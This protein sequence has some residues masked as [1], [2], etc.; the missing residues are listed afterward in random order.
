MESKEQRYEIGVLG[1]VPVGAVLHEPGA[2]FH[3]EVARFD[4]LAVGDLLGARVADNPEN[5]VAGRGAG[6]DGGGGARGGHVARG[7]RG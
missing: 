5:V 3:A 6:D 2:A 1:G 7:G 4:A